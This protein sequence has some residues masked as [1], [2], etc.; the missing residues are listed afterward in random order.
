M[1]ISSFELAKDLMI[2][3]PR[4]IM[5]MIV[6]ALSMALMDGLTVFSLAPIADALIH[7][8]ITTQFALTRGLMAGFA[9]VGIDPSPLNLLG[10]VLIFNV[11]RFF[12]QMLHSYIILR[13]KYAVIGDMLNELLT[14]LFNANW[15]FFVSRRSGDFLNVMQREF[16]FVGESFRFL[17]DLI[18]AATQLAILLAIPLYLSWKTTA[19]ILV[20]GAL[21]SAVISRMARR[22]KHYGKLNVS[23]GNDYTSTLFECFNS[24]KLILAFAK[25]QKMIDHVRSL[26]G[27][28]YS[29]TVRSQ[30]LQVAV[31]GIYQPV[32]FALVVITFA[33]ASATQIPIGL[34]VMLLYS[35]N[36]MIPVARNLASL[37]VQ[38]DLVAPSYGYI[39]TVKKEAQDTPQI[40]GVEVFEGVNRS[41][42]LQNISFSYPNQTPVLKN[43][44]LSVPKGKMIALVGPSGAGKS[45]LI[46]IIM[47]FN[48]PQEGQVAIDDVPLSTYDI[49]SV[50][51]RFGV[52]LQDAKLLNMSIKDNLLWANSNATDAQIIEACEQAN[53]ME[54]IQALPDKLDTV[55]G[56]RGV[57]LSGGQGQRLA[58]A[59][60]IVRQPDLLILD[61]ATSALDSESE[62]KIQD[63]IDTIAKHT[64]IVVIAHRLSTIKRA[65]IIYVINN[66]NVI[67]KGS[68]DELIALDQQFNEMLQRQMGITR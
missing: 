24:V 23:T 52:V 1:K 28:H 48:S 56:E 25:G 46:D 34:I 64:T 43:L 50:R 37:K 41:I 63:A 8:D 67:E 54:F 12:I 66:S 53:A 21:I 3:Y 6:G 45:T 39:K 58:L 38:L 42:E 16:L 65:D 13:I 22:A 27:V 32:G 44:N 7:S 57:R 17:A 29:A 20:S 11:I 36:R 40:T 2:R 14:Q 31:S 30:M 26:F 61:E 62:S 4:K 47:G 33:Y 68:Y 60:A 55:I 51:E 10:L 49:F 59:R 15:Q 19:L 5:V 18:A 9:K 35:I